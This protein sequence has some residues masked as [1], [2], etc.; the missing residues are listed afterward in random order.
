MGKNGEKKKKEKILVRDGLLIT[1]ERSISLEKRN[2]FHKCR[3]I[4]CFAETNGRIISNDIWN[5]RIL[6]WM[7]EK[8]NLDVANGGQAKTERSLLLLAN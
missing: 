3:P 1:V 7:R 4:N 8:R 5:I 6:V 2:V